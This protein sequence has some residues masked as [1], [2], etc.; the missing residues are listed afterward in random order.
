MAFTIA[1][2]GKG[3]VGKTTLSALTVRHFAAAGANPV[4]AVDADSN[5]NLHELL[6]IPCPPTVGGIREDARSRAAELKGI[7]KHEFLDLRVNE[8]LVEQRGYDLLAMGRPEGQGCYCFANNVLRDVLQK[9]AANYHTIVLDSEAGLE[10]IA[11]RTLFALDWLV[12]VSDCTVRGVRT[13]ARISALADEVKL[14]AAH[15]GLVVNRVADGILPIAVH[16]EIEASGLDLLAAIPFDPSVAAMDAGGACVDDIP[17]GAPVRL[18]AQSLI[19]KLLSPAVRR[20]LD[21]A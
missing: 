17:A 19:D 8:A 4:L 20:D 7:S 2:T 10:H 12:L 9:L 11:R 16:A 1:M 21:V 14:P 5:I 18:A 13:A 6:G 3:G 15:R